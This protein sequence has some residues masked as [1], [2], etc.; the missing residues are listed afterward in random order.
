MPDEIAMLEQQIASL[1]KKR[2]ELL[3]KAAAQPV[4]NYR[5]KRPDGASVALADLFGDKRDLLL[6]HNMGR[7]CA[8]CT[9]WADGFNSH[10]PYYADRAAFVLAS[11]DEPATLT[12]FSA[13]RGWRFPTVSIHGSTIAKDLGFEP[14]PGKFWPGVSAL[15]KDDNGSIRRSGM[16]HFGPGDDFCPVWPMFDLLEEGPNDWAPR[17]NK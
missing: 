17:Y 5:L 16:S 9:L 8:Y 13:S 10:Y 2:T 12:E 6:I 4:E 7:G 3:R 11:P 15:R 1:K 14:E